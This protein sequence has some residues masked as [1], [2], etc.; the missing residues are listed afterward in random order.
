MSTVK[1]FAVV[2]CLFFGLNMSVQADWSYVGNVNGVRIY[3]DNLTGL[4]WT[5]TLGKVPSSEYGRS[6]RAEVSALGFRLP[7]FYELQQMER[8]GGFSKLKI[9]STS[10]YETN[11][12][13]YLANASG[14]GFRT[15]LARA[16]VGSNL[17]IG[18]REASSDQVVVVT[19][20]SPVTVTQASVTSVSTATPPKTSTVT[21]TKITPASNNTPISDISNIGNV[22]NKPETA[23]TTKASDVTLKNVST[24]T[25]PQNNSLATIELAQATTAKYGADKSSSAS[26]KSTDAIDNDSAEEFD[27]GIFPNATLPFV[28]VASAALLKSTSDNLKDFINGQIELLRETIT[29]PEAT[30]ENLIIKLRDKKVDNEKIA[31]I[32]RALEE[33]DAQAF[34]QTWILVGGDV[35]D[36]GRITRVIGLLSE[37]DEF[38]EAINDNKTTISEDD[39]RSYRKTFEKSKLSKDITKKIKQ[40]FAT[41]ETTLQLREDLKK[42]RGK[43]D[44]EYYYVPIEES[45]VLIISP[46]AESDK[47][48]AVNDKVFIYGKKE[49]E[50]SVTEKTLEEYVKKPLMSSDQPVTGIT[51][52]DI[53]LTNLLDAEVKFDLDGTKFTLAG[54]ETKSYPCPQSNKI[55]IETKAP[56]TTTGRRR[57][58]PTKTPEPIVLPVNAG[59]TYSIQKNGDVFELVGQAIT[60][61]LDNRQGTQP[62]YCTVK[63]EIV[64]IMTGETKEFKGDNGIVTITFARSDDNTDISTITLNASDTYKPAISKNDGKWA[65]FNKDAKFDVK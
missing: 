58:T 30:S 63:E 28:S 4:E 6:A 31:A 14:N 19:S 50:I 41:I 2:F 53:K 27:N 59:G 9:R 22:S 39:F 48:F 45:A 11:N 25:S 35:I 5:E 55:K 36:G 1:K 38:E 47:L 37:L 20:P 16:G 51:N 26:T 24:S 61:K 3:L 33:N 32:V 13:D 42:P 7:S 57:I 23:I 52:T 62:F 56:V 10:Y 43:D 46:K 21:T 15:P 65:L 40:I 12:P 60:V 44:P 34:Q 49:A 18:V 8:H 17:V 29:I 64:T 54:K